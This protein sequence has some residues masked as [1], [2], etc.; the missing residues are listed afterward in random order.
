MNVPVCV[1]LESLG[2]TRNQAL[3]AYL[4]CDKNEQ[5][6]ANFLLENM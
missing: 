1:Q 5:L 2:F 6:A 3:E 4:A